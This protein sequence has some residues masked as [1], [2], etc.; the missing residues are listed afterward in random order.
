MNA[1]V[2]RVVTGVLLFSSAGCSGERILTMM[3]EPVKFLE[4]PLSVNY[5]NDLDALERRYLRKDISYVEYLEKK[6]RIE[7]DY[8]RQEQKRRDTVENVPLEER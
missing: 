3:D 2:I 7:D 5:Q 6:Q 1:V 4:D 8:A